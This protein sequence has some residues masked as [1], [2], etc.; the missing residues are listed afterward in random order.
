MMLMH[1]LN[2]LALLEITEECGFAGRLGNL[3]G[4]V[5][6]LVVGVVLMRW[7]KRRYL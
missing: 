2:V 7:A 1:A 5:V 3:V 6:G 4:I